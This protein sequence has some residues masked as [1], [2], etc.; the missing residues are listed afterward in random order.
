M[1]LALPELW[2]ASMRLPS[3]ING[4]DLDN[5]RRPPNRLKR[6]FTVQ[7]SGYKTEPFYRRTFP[8]VSGRDSERKPPKMARTPEITTKSEVQADPEA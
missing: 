5:V 2:N 4:L 3:E 6:R 1:L 7:I 8:V